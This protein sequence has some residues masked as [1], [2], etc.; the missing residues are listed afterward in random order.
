[1]NTHRIANALR[2]A[3]LSAS[4]AAGLLYAAPGFAADAGQAPATQAPAATPAAHAA[5]KHVSRVEA[6][7]AKLHEELHITPA[8]ETQWSAVAE[9]MRD[10][11]KAIH[12][13]VVERNAKT[14]TM[15][16]V[17]DLRSYAAISDARTDGLKKLI[18]AFDA[19]YGAMTDD[20]KKVADAMFRHV[21]HPH[22]AHKS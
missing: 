21:R 18:P 16:A 7:L 13:L 1:M 2:G 14:A 6:R 5:P 20:Q 10:N 11:A 8:Q 4:L 12:A 9:A 17:D 15:N 22:V 3:A 19:L